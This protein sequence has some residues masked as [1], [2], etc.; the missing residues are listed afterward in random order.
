LSRA[1]TAQ[2][3]GLATPPAGGGADSRLLVEPNETVLPPAHRGEPRARPNDGGGAVCR[4]DRISPAAEPRRRR[5]A[6]NAAFCRAVLRAIFQ[7]INQR[8]AH[9]SRRRERPGM[10][11]I[12]PDGSAPVQRTID[13]PRNA[14]GQTTKPAGEHLRIIRFDDEMQVVILHTEM[15]NP[16]APVRG[17]GERAADGRKDPP[18]AQ[19]TDGRSGPERCVHGLRRDVRRPRNMRHAGPT[20]GRGFPPSPRPAPTPGARARKGQ[21]LQA[22]C[23]VDSAIIALYLSCVKTGVFDSRRY[24]RRP[25]PVLAPLAQRAAATRDAAAAG[26]SGGRVSH[27]RCRPAQPGSPQ[28]REYDHM[29]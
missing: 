23:H 6:I 2:A 19:A 10:V 12:S 17:H 26:L 5:A 8:V 24:S 27:P 4:Y 22:S 25:T 21:L 14:N 20:A 13:R 16:E 11:P 7:Y 1:A 15:E 9:R 18:R 28:S 29:S 3:R